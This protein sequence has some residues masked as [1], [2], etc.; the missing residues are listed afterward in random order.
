M[1]GRA[2]E[3]LE[4]TPIYRGFFNLTRFTLRHTLFQGGWSEPLERELF[5]RGECVAVLPYDPISDEVLLIE[6]FRIGAE[7]IKPTPWMLEIIAGAVE[8]GETHEAVARREALEE[9]GCDL[10]DL[11]RVGEFFT[12]PGGC[13]ER[14]SVFVGIP[15]RPLEAGTFGLVEEGEDI[16]GLVLSFF[17]AMALLA[18]GQIDSA[19]PALALQWLALNRSRLRDR[20]IA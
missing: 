8:P 18:D 10:A 13:S 12:T 14:V 11:I 17:E 7:G 15:S 5:H 20:D 1:A 19:I 4:K 9:A 16:R 2:T 3:I 6:Q